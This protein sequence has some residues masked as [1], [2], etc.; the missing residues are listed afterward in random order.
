MND[1]Y[2]NVK[3]N[4][5]KKEQDVSAGSIRQVLKEGFDKIIGQFSKKIEEIQ[6]D[7]HKVEIT[8]AKDISFP[9][10]Q[11]VEVTNQQEAKF[12]DVQRVEVVNPV[13]VPDV[14]KVEITN[15]KDAVFPGKMKVEVT[16]PTT[17][18][19]PTGEGDTPGKANPSKYVPVR[20]TDGKHF[21]NALADA[22]VAASSSGQSKTK[23][24]ETIPTDPSKSNASI[25]TTEATV[26]DVTTT[27]VVKTIG[28]T[29]YTKTVAKNNV[30]NSVT[31]S[32]WA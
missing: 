1:I 15:Q 28:S 26:G 4:K 10:V 23:I 12:P 32:S 27:T 18:D 9:E 31:V 13:A 21:Y 20:L 24:L 8:N 11:K 22:Y 16:N 17:I 25:T 30:T 5:A 14:Q 2:K 19:L 7:M 3:I 6:V 29:S